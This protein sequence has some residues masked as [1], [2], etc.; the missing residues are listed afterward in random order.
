VTGG[1]SENGAAGENRAGP[2]A[3]APRRPSPDNFYR[4]CGGGRYILYGS[5]YE[6]NKACG[7]GGTLV[8]PHVLM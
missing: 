3:C 6:L 1:V 2:P 5:T 7:N 8:T 4:P